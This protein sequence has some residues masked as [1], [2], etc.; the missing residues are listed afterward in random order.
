[1][2]KL[3][4]NIK[5][6]KFVIY[7]SLIAGVNVNA[8]DIKHVSLD[9]SQSAASPSASGKLLKKYLNPKKLYL[10][11]STALIVDETDDVVLYNKEANKKNAHCFCD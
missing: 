2:A 8:A 4:L 10:R 1:M 6:L 7:L 3:M 5:S 9:N 11:S